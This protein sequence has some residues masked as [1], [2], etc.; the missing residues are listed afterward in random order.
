MF[1]KEAIAKN[2]REL[3]AYSLACRSEIGVSSTFTIYDKYIVQ[4]VLRLGFA[5]STKGSYEPSNNVGN[6]SCD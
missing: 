6:E 3:L 4:P 2:E 1:S 5:L